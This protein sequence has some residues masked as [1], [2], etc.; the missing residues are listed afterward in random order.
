M[1]VLEVLS[2]LGECNIICSPLTITPTLVLSTEDFSRISSIVPEC[3]MS[4]S[5]GSEVEDTEGLKEVKLIVGDV[6]GIKYT[7]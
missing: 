7:R 5:I 3:S 2:Q 1:T 6:C 4:V